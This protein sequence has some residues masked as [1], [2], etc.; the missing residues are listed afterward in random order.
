ML[1]FSF[2]K[3]HNNVK[4]YFSCQTNCV[5]WTSKVNYDNNRSF[6]RN[7]RSKIDFT[8]IELWTKKRL[9]IAFF[10]TRISKSDS[11]T[12]PNTLIVNF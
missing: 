3:V 12:E 10:Y 11:N 4:Y 7:T 8:Q 9:I 6:F 1:P 5:K 2:V